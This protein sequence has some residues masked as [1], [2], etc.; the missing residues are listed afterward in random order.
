MKDKEIV[1]LD[2]LR[3]RLVRLLRAHWDVV[4]N[5]DKE[6]GQTCT[7]KMRIDTGDHASIKLSLICWNQG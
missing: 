1:A 3:A 4:A 2:Q 6:L 5:L 7:V